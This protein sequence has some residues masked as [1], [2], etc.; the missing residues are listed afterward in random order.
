MIILKIKT[1]FGNIIKKQQQIL[2]YAL[3]GGVTQ[4]LDFATYTILVYIGVNY[5]IA[6]LAN[7]PLVLGFNYLGHKYIT[8][9]NTKWSNKEI[10][11]YLINLVV[12]YLYVTALLILL[13][14]ILNIDP[15]IS[16]FITIVAIPLVNFL[17]LK[18]FVFQ[19][20]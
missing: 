7:N 6:D 9:D 12:N 2:K 5:V 20:K 15:V 4:L 16:K 18:K 1:E 19:K 8:F 10:G 3:V 13:T 14:S 17:L 11:R